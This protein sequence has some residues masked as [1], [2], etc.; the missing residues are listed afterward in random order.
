MKQKIKQN[1]IKPEQN[2]TKKQT[3]TKDKNKTMQNKN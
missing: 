1:Q 3:K 2:E